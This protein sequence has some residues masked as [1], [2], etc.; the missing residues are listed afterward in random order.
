MA[1]PGFPPESQLSNLTLA[2]GVDESFKHDLTALLPVQQWSDA[3]IESIRSIVSAKYPGSEWQEESEWI[4][5]LINVILASREGWNWQ[6]LKTCS[7][8]EYF[9][10]PP[11]VSSNS[12]V[13]LS[14]A[15]Q[16]RLILFLLPITVLARILIYNESVS[17]QNDRQSHYST[18]SSMLVVLMWRM[19]AARRAI[20]PAISV[21]ALGMVEK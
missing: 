2:S 10:L 12:L 4:R 11:H 18:R 17:L 16:G 1:E 9:S 3:T 14:V 13:L 21:C 19:H 8:T 6:R 15:V 5:R 7:N 20:T